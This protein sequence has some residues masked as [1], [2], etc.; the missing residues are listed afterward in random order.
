MGR[1]KTRGQQVP[2]LPNP[3][4]GSLK[5]ADKTPSL[6]NRIARIRSVP[7]RVGCRERVGW[8]LAAH[9][10]LYVPRQPESVHIRFSR[11]V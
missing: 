1:G 8:A 10:F 11:P 4:S 5:A 3:F 2:T 6:H 9:A 7:M